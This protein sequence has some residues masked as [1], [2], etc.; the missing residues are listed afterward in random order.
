MG[1][2]KRAFESS[3][4]VIAAGKPNLSAY[5]CGNYWYS[6]D[7]YEPKFPVSILYFSPVGLALK[8]CY[9]SRYKDTTELIAWLTD[10]ETI[11]TFS[12]NDNSRD[13]LPFSIEEAEGE[14]NLRLKIGNQVFFGQR[15][16]DD[17]TIDKVQLGSL[18]PRSVSLDHK[19]MLA[20]LDEIV[21]AQSSQFVNRYIRHR[22][23]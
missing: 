23:Q 1:T 4:D 22:P 19:A 15:Y 12:L 10:G 13:Q 3:V 14:M 20:R 21:G 5:L 2:I 16:I 18:Q 9:E 11:T 6:C 8:I 7:P 17:L